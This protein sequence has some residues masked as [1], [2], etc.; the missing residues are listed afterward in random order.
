[1]NGKLYL[2][3]KCCTRV[4]VSMLLVTVFDL[5]GCA[6]IKIQRWITVEK[7]TYNQLKCE[8]SRKNFDEENP[9]VHT[10]YD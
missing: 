4:C 8:E 3:Y 7:N 9:T 6:A 5:L 2:M 1:M 10:V